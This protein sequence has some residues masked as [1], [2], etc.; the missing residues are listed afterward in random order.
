MSERV[1]RYRRAIHHFLIEAPLNIQKLSELIQ[2]LDHQ[3]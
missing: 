3:K 2:Q 1:L